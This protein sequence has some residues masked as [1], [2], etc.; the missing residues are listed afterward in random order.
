MK[1]TNILKEILLEGVSK[2]KDNIYISFQNNQTDLLSTVNSDVTRKGVTI[3]YTFEYNERNENPEEI[4]DTA[5]DLKDLKNVDLN[6]L[7]EVLSKSIR[8]FISKNFTPD[9][10]YYLGSSKGLSKLIADIVKEE[11]SEIEVIPLNKKTFPSWKE[12]LVDDYEQKIKT[13]SLLNTVENMAK[14]MWEKE[15]GKIKS[16]GKYSRARIYFKPKY[17]LEKIV[18]RD[19]M[20][21]VDDNVQ[22][23]TDFQFIN[24]HLKDVRKLMFYVA[25]KLPIEGAKTTKASIEISKKVCLKTLDPKYFIKSPDKLYISNSHPEIASLKKVLSNT[26]QSIPGKGIYYYF[27]NPN[28]KSIEDLKC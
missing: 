2:Y 7:K 1:L 15:E 22:T 20:L 11:Y 3:Y 16:S 25:I 17:E 21:F 23:G 28:I 27:K 12:M 13:K 6:S 24:N 10:V 9:V 14:E 8:S 5:D 26:S 4:K 19:K 18:A